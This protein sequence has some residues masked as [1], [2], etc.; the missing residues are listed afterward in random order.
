MPC[1]LND[2]G[3]SSHCLDTSPDST[4]A[5]RISARQRWD[6][7]DARPGKTIGLSVG[8]DL[9]DELADSLLGNGHCVPMVHPLSGGA[10]EEEG[11]ISAYATIMCGRSASV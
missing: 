1:L 9:R 2:Q 10:A 5:Q 7:V 8:G 3:F 6:N 11:S 4:G